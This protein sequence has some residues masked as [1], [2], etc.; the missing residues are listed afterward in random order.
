ML[1]LLLHVGLALELAAASL[2]PIRAS[3]AP[4][5]DGSLDDAAWAAA[6]V[7]KSFVQ[8]FPDEGAPPAEATTVRVVY[9]DEAVYFGIECA[10]PDFSVVARLTR[11]DRLVEADRVEVSVGPGGDGKSAF[12]CAVTAAGVLVDGIRYDDPE[13]ALSGDENWEAEP[14]RT[15]E[16]WTAEIKIPLRILRFPTLP[17]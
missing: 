7:S 17:A 12:H 15:A 8:K 5:I 4:V 2:T 10:Q 11:R 14:C 3:R 9:D 13:L 6:A 1:Q 16:G